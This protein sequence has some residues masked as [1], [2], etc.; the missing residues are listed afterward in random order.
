MV[1]CHRPAGRYARWNGTGFRTASTMNVFFGNAA[2]IASRLAATDGRQYWQPRRRLP[3]LL[4][5]GKISRLAQSL[6]GYLL[7]GI[8]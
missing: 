7:Q 6:S 5:V 1:I 8:R 2:M 4:L 3:Y